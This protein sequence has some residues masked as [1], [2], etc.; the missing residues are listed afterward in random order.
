M[1]KLRG[2]V[3]CPRSFVYSLKLTVLGSFEEERIQ[4]LREENIEK[5]INF[6]QLVI[7]VL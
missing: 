2:K 4:V 7:Y 1:G 5:K 6:E 3:R